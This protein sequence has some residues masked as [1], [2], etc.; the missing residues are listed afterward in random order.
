MGLIILVQRAPVL[1]RSVELSA[2]FPDDPVMTTAKP[3][4]EMTLA[5]RVL[6]S[7]YPR[8][9]M[10]VPVVHACYDRLV[11]IVFILALYYDGLVAD[12]PGR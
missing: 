7:S 5:F 6:P 8:G 11:S 9:A 4:L 12:S 10:G 2:C 1:C 3:T